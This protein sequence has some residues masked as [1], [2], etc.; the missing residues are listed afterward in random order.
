[1]ND[2]RKV[3]IDIAT[4]ASAFGV[5]EPHQIKFP[6]ELPGPN[7]WDE[8]GPDDFGPEHD[9]EILDHG[10]IIIFTPISNAALQWCYKHLPESAPRHGRV[11]YVV[12][13]RYIDDIVA[14][15]RRDGLMSEEDFIWA[16]EEAN[17]IQHQGENL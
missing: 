8:V 4:T 6:H 2:L 14:G 10:S 15:A 11:G 17:A 16:M 7:N 12:E 1:M 9:F 3:M 13:P 5:N